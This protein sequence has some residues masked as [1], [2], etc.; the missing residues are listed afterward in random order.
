MKLRITSA[1]LWGKRDLGS[2]TEG[3]PRELP[4]LVFCSPPYSFFVEREAEMLELIQRIAGTRRR[5]AR[6]SSN[7]IKDLTS[8][9]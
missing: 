1:F 4:W 3:P 7:R 5:I 9:A 6:S 2:E 8:P